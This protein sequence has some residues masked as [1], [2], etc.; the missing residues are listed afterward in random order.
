MLN[1]KNAKV[2]TYVKRP[3]S[4]E[5]KTHVQGPNAQVRVKN[6]CAKAKTNEKRQNRMCK[7]PNAQVRVKNVCAKA[8]TNEKRQNRMCKGQNALV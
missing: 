8:K 4:Y 5:V 7:G 3:L 6:A 1:L 2:K